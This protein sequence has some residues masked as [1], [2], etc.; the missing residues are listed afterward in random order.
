MARVCVDACFLIGLYDKDDQ[1][2]AVAIRQFD[3]LFGEK[4]PRHI[5]VAPWPILYEC[6]GTQQAKNP[7]KVS[8]LSRYWDYLGRYGQLIRLDDLPYREQQLDEHMEE[9]LRPL[10]LVDRVLR[11]MIQDNRSL[12]DYF[13][14]YNTG[15]FADACQC[16]GIPLLN[17][18]VLPE[19]YDIG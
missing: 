9:A 10:S 3:A 5:L 7:R 19:A 12:F 16:R 13:L 4:S 14:T 18:N 6:C 17:E 8:T 1:H 2:H 11:A 15:D